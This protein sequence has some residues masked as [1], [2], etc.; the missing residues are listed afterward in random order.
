MAKTNSI[1]ILQADGVTAAPLAESYANIINAFEKTA[2]SPILKSQES[3]LVGDPLSGSVLVHRL[4]TSTVR[5][6]G[7]A[8][9]AG[10]GDLMQDDDVTV[11]L[12]QRKEIVEEVNKFDATQFGVP[13]MVASRE[14]NFASSLRNHLDRAFFTEAEAEGTSTDVSAFT[15]LVDQIEALI[16]AVE[17]TTNSHTDG[18]DRDMIAL[19]LT[20]QI[21]GQLHNYIDTLSNPVEGGVDI[22]TFHGVR[23][24]SNHRQTEDAICMVMGAVA[25]PVALIDFATEDIQLSANM[26]MMLFFN[27]GT[28]AVMP[29]LIRYADLG[30]EVSA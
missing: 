27:Y 28:E 14:P 23:V 18:V 10:A 11:N 30:V 29:D 17:T 24:Y 19:T 4:E 12:N 21:Y 2:L 26:A 15:T 5:N 13:A 8:R 1:S 16:Q 3:Q 20:P 9:A 6:Q 22:K 7:T 25:Q